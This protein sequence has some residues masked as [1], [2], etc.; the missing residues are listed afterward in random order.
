MLIYLPLPPHI[1]ANSMN[2]D[3]RKMLFILMMVLVLNRMMLFMLK[4]MLTMLILF[5]LYMTPTQVRVCLFV[6]KNHNILQK[7]YSFFSCESVTKNKYFLHLSVWLLLN[8]TINMRVEMLCAVI[9]FIYHWYKLTTL[10]NLYW[11][12]ISKS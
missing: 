8:S 3:V 1:F 10:Q 12:T 2:F 6:T 7:N 9:C 5:Y 11:P 4:L